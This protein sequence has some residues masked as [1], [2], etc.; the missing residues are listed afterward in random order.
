VV[1]GATA[2]YTPIISY[3]GIGATVSLS[4]QSTVRIQ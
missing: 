2:T 3:P 1:V 4:A